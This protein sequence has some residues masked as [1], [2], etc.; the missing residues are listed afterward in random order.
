MIKAILKF[1]EGLVVGSIAGYVA[2]LLSAPK[3]GKQLRKEISDHSEQLCKQAYD[4][5]DDL[6]DTT[7]NTVHDL[8]SKT[9]HGM[10]D[11][12]TKG[13][14]LLKNAALNVREAGKKV[15]NKFDT[16][17]THA[18]NALVDENEIIGG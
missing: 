5:L 13:E 11:I 14:Q 6:A 2:G 8:Q 3:T 7:A 15:A 17:M 16:A 1:L 12:E 9:V 4:T 10:H 18:A